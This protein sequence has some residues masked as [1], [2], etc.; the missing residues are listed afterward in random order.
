MWGSV[1]KGPPGV[2]DQPR[3]WSKCEGLANPAVDKGGD[4]DGVGVACSFRDLG[5]D[6]FTTKEPTPSTD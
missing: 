2:V 5:G 1:A 6:I 3:F 4:L